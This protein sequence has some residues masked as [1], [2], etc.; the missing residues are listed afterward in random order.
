MH[1][2]GALIVF[3][4]VNELLV[5]ILG[6]ES[7]GWVLVVCMIGFILSTST[8]LLYWVWECLNWRRLEEEREEKE[9]EKRRQLEQYSRDMSLSCHKCGELAAPIPDSGNRYRCT[10]GHQFAAAK[11]HLT[12]T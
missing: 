1:I 5:G 4:I 9:K 10:C 11:H 3:V 7:R 8:D 2:L 6:E 12:S